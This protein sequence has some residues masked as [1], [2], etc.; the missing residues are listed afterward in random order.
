[1][2]L[3]L[4]LLVPLGGLLATWRAVPSGEVSPPRSGPT[5]AADEA[6]DTW[7]FGGYAE[8]EG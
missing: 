5:A 6:G 7:L 1:M 8:E 2:W 3:V 4:E